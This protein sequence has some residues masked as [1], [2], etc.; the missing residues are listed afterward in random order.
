MNLPRRK[1]LHLTAGATALS[2]VSR[3]ARGQTY[4]ARPIRIIVGFAAGGGQDIIARLMGQWLSERLGQTFLVDNR[5]GANGNIATEAVVKAP[6][7]G[8]TLLHFSS[9]IAINATLY[10]KLQFDFLRD[11]LPI[12]ILDSALT[13]RFHLVLYPCVVI[14]LIEI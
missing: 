2:A 7:D 1:F 11:I 3:V 8:Y 14:T 5:P 9:T 10:E 13:K 4:P 12:D 6:S